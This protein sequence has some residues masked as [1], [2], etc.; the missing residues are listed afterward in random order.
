[1]KIERDALRLEKDNRAAESQE[2]DGRLLVLSCR[3]PKGPL[4]ENNKKQQ[5][6]YGHSLIVELTDGC[7]ES[8]SEL[9]I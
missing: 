9:V 6:S 8:P 7:P 5:R 2:V 3:A 4:V 1:V